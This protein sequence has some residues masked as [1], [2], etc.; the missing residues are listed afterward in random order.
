MSLTSYFFLRPRKT[1]TGA[2]GVPIHINDHLC[3]APYL[4]CVL[5]ISTMPP[6]TTGMPKSA[7]AKPKRKGVLKNPGPA[8][9]PAST[10]DPTNKK[11]LAYSSKDKEQIINLNKKLEDKRKEHDIQVFF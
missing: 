1:G 7:K 11:G 2:N 3:I 10:Q 6:K 8:V 5:S 9:P 4:R